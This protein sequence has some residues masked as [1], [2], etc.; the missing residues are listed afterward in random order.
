M[1]ST[2][3]HHGP[4]QHHPLVGPLDNAN[5]ALLA[6]VRPA[7]WTN[8]PGD[9]VYDLVVIGGGTAGLVS[10]AWAAGLGARVA[11]V[12]RALLG[13]DCLNSGRVPSKAMLRSARAVA[14]ARRA[15]SLGIRTGDIDVD[16]GAVKARMRTLR[17]GISPHDSAERLTKIGV[18][19]FLGDGRFTSLRTVAVD[20]RSLRFKRAVIA[21]GGRASAPPIPGLAEVE[22][23]TNETLFWLLGPVPIPQSVASS[24][25]LPQRAQRNGEQAV[26]ELDCGGPVIEDHASREAAA[27]GGPE[28][29]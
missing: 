5:R 29:T 26:V 4:A 13:G 11:L 28:F 8:P 2:P 7:G 24:R 25:R 17:A 27:C 22:Y 21:T 19:V 12:E 14:E 9:G 16:F 10:A 3:E 15:P 20:G 6:Q 18:D 1:A 23:L